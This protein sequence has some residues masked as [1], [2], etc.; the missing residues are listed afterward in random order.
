MRTRGLYI[1]PAILA[2]TLTAGALRCPAQ[3]VFE[4][5]KHGPITIDEKDVTYFSK[6]SAELFI[7]GYNLLATRGSDNRLHQLDD[8]IRNTG[9][10]HSFFMGNSGLPVPSTFMTL[11]QNEF[12]LR[13]ARKNAATYIEKKYQALKA[14]PLVWCDSVLKFG[15]FDF[16]KSLYSLDG[17]LVTVCLSLFN[18]ARY[19]KRKGAC[20]MHTLLDNTKGIPAFM[21]ITDGKESEL[22]VA[23]DNW[24]SWNH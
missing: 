3:S 5:Y 2:L 21:S 4:R 15:R 12:N 14:K 16:G 7:H 6:E 23:R 8:F 19:R 10:R 1:L 20:R 9:R 22:A 13:V 18:W 24:K 11:E 17:S